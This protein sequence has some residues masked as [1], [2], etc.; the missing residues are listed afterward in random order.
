MDDRPDWERELEPDY[1]VFDLDEKVMTLKELVGEIR[2][3]VWH[4]TELEPGSYAHEHF[5]QTGHKLRFGC[6]NRQTLERDTFASEALGSA[7]GA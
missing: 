2:K 6:C 4:A 3:L 1:T 7:H 5:V